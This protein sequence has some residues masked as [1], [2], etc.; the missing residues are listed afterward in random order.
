MPLVE[1]IPWSVVVNQISMK[2]AQ[3]THCS[4]LGAT[5][6]HT[7]TP[8]PS[9][10]LKK[11]DHKRMSHVRECEPRYLSFNFEFTIMY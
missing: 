4:G 5:V 7:E 6:A 11:V 9:L 10:P 3:D 8:P 2:H 1:K